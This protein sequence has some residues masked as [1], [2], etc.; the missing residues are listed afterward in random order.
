MTVSDRIFK[1]G[2]K[3]YIIHM[4]WEILCSENMLLQ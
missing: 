1:K 2:R 3:L 4:Y